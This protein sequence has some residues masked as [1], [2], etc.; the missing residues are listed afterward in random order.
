[1]PGVAMPCAQDLP[2]GLAGALD[3]DIITWLY[4]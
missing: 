4:I 3:L 1:L 2:R